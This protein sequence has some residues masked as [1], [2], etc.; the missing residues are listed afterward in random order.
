MSTLQMLFTY[1]SPMN[2]WFESAP[3]DWQEWALVLAV[4]VAIYAVIGAEK[5]LG[6]HWRG[7]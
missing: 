5:W 3:L 4:G 7:R 6:R 1:W 2:R